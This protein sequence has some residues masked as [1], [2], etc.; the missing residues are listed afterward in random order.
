[1]RLRLATRGSTLAWTQ[2]GT[3]ADALRALGHEVELVKVTTH[4]DV[5]SAPLASLGGAGVFV[6]AVRAAVLAGEADLAVHSFKDLPTAA[7][8]GLVIAAVPLREDPADAL[9][10]REGW[11]LATRAPRG[12]VARVHPSR[13]HS[14][15]AGSSRSGTA[16]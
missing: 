3:V 15:S 9:C 11:T 6:G 2:S 4:G 10:A 14:A 16:A 5:S 13:A 7:A 12:R 1:M 8:E